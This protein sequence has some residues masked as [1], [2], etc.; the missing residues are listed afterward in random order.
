MYTYVFIVACLLVY[1]ICK[2]VCIYCSEHGMLRSAVLSSALAM[3]YMSMV[4]AMTMTI[5]Y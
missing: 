1:V 5:D 4:F 2:S 3:I